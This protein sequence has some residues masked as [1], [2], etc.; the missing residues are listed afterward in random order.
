[1][2]WT[3]F[4]DM[5][6]GGG[7]K[8]DW[9]QIFIEAPR[10]EAESVFSARFGRSPNRVTCTC[11]GPD[12]SVNEEPTLEQITWFER[13]C[14]L[15]KDGAV[16]EEQGAEYRPYLTL[17]EYIARKDVKVIPANE[18]SEQERAAIVKRQG[19]IWVDE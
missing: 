16:I 9:A 8:L 5:N 14:K 1:M 19:Y 6:S 11:C 2:T 12:Y 4:H 10:K 7:Q 15:S 13:G 17:R 18:I 3:Q